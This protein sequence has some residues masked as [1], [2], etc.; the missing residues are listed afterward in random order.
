MRLDDVRMVGVFSA[1]VARVPKIRV[2]LGCERLIF[3]P[4]ASQASSLDAV[5]G[6]G[7]KAT[8]ERARDYAR[9]HGVPYLALEDGFLRSVGLGRREAPLSVVVDDLGVYY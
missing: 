4:S 7:H 1:G 8:A 5:V 6:W 3:R 9:R 2:F